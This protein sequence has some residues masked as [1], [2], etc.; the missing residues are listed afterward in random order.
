MKAG[1][2]LRLTLM[3]SLTVV[4]GLLAIWS[5]TP[6]PIRA[7]HQAELMALAGGRDVREDDL[8]DEV[9][10]AGVLVVA[11]DPNYA[12][13]SFLNDQGELDGFDVDVAKEVA[14]R[15]GVALEFQTPP[16][17]EVVAGYWAAVWDVSIGSMTPTDQRA[18]VLWFTDPYY[19]WSASFAIHQDNTTF[20]S[21]TQLAGQRVG[22]AEWSL[23]EAYLEGTLDVQDYGRVISYPPPES[24]TICSYPNDQAAVVDL[25]VG[26][27]VI[28]DAILSSQLFIHSVIEEGVP[29]KTLGT[30][31][32]SDPV[33][34]ALDQDR[35]PSDL[36]IAA[37]NGIIADMHDDGT[38]ASISIKWLDIDI[39][40]PGPQ[41]PE[42]YPDCEGVFL[43]IVLR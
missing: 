22:V 41:W 42:C 15:L 7:Q 1:R 8:L 2:L 20:T 23:N 12:P 14:R 32:F 28:L 30:S 9:L 29:I 39:T 10:T 5:A 37:L 25:A 13:W 35:G 40:E 33:V 11:T 18:L 38:L 21:V 3:L 24:V 19:F 43:P 16:W 6:V 34:F 36:M 31:A 17:S 27:G 4:T 26:D